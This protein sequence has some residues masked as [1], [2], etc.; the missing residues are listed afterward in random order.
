[1]LSRESGGRS[2]I[3][4]TKCPKCGARV[5]FYR[6]AVG[7]KVYFDELGGDWPQHP[8][9]DVE[10]SRRANA[11]RPRASSWAIVDD[12]T[13]AWTGA[14]LI[15][16]R[17]PRD[18]ALVGVLPRERL[19]LIPGEYVSFSGNM[20]EKF[21]AQA[22]RRQVVRTSRVDLDQ[23]ELRLRPAV[24]KHELEAKRGL[25]VSPPRQMYELIAINRSAGGAAVLTLYSEMSP[26]ARVRSAWTP[27]VQVG[28]FV[29][30]DWEAQQLTY[31]GWD[32]DIAVAIA[33]Q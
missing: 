29:A 18:K 21:D 32:C 28:D 24:E 31:A 22:S 11:A 25:R 9:T 1:M 33:R 14:Q 27:G 5:L 12:A 23:L 6:N 2:Q 4:P 13:D 19:R 10:V 16:F 3:W 8:C 26:L 17:N 15:I 20:I 30:L 7:S